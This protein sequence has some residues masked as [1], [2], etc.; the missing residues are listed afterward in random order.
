[1]EAQFSTVPSKTFYYV[2]SSEQ[3]AS[4]FHWNVL[5]SIAGARSKL[6]VVPPPQAIVP[7]KKYTFYLFIFRRRKKGRETSMCGCLLLTPY[8]GPGPQI[9]HVP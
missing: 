8:W 9:R 3:Q 1:M 4:Y 5:G 2:L 7:L 6:S